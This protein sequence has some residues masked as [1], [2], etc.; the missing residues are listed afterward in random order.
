MKL[1]KW[2]A[3]K[4]LALKRPAI[5]KK[6]IIPVLGLV[7]LLGLLAVIRLVSLKLTPELPPEELWDT[8]LE[9]TMSANS[10]RYQVEMIFDGKTNL[11]GEGER[12]SPDKVH[13]KGTMDSVKLEFIQIGETGYMRDPYSKQWLALEGN[14][15]SNSELFITELNPLGM[16][17]FKDIPEIK[18]QGEE[19]IGDE[20]CIVLNLQPNVA[21]PF[22]ENFINFDYKV[23]I[24]SKD[25]FIKQADIKAVSK[26]QNQVKFNLKLKFSDYNG[27]IT[28]NPPPVG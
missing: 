5:N 9:N 19:E 3:P 6:I 8:A 10:Y 20:Q 12:L 18:A 17:N 15:L 7:L 26:G 27:D 16:F 24:S 2:S 28:I 22:M 14:Q 25:K 11:R 13:L 1:P 21:N 4:G 23:W